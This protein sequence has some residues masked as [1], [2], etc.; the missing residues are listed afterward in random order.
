MWY[1]STVN[2]FGNG[3]ISCYDYTRKSG[4]IQPVSSLV[5]GELH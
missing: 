3:S 2:D 1:I 5:T 4:T